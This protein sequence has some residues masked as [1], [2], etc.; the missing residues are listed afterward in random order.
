[1]ALDITNELIVRKA[2]ADLV[3][4]VAEAG[5]VIPSARY[6]SGIE[7]FWA[8]T[9]PT[10]LTQEGLETSYIAATWI[11]TISFI[12]DFA[13]GCSDKPLYNLT[14]EMYIFRQYGEMREDESVTP[15]VFDSKVLVQH[16]DFIAG[17]LGIKEAF[18]RRANIAG[19]SGAFVTAETQPI[20]QT[21]PI[22]NQVICEFIP[23]VVGFAVRLQET[24]RLL[25]VG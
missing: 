11:Y 16:N 2:V 5:Y 22:A 14:Y 24:V 10:K 23:G 4:T 9:D 20:V 6:T 7:S 17:W 13:S 3:G 12:D 15:V 25:E 19:L 8:S 18:Q 1:M 21:E